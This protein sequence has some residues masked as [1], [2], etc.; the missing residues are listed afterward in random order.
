MGGEFS[1]QRKEDQLYQKSLDKAQ[2][3]MRQ[4]DDAQIAKDHKEKSMALQSIA[5][6]M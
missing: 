6:S 1:L 2:M 4:E 3:E 5:T